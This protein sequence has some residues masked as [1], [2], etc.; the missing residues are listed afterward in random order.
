MMD[1]RRRAADPGRRKMT[2][3]GEEPIR[4]CWMRYVGLLLA[5]ISVTAQAVPIDT[6]K[7]KV[8]VEAAE[9]GQKT[10][11]ADTGLYY[12]RY[13][14]E[15]VEVLETDQHF[16]EKIQSAD[17]EDIKSGKISKELDLV[18]HHVRTKL[19]ELKR[20]EVARLRM[21]IKAKLSAPDSAAI[22]RKAL[23]QQFN[24][25][26]HMNPDSFEPQDLDMLI[27]AATKDLENFDK[28]RHDEFKR[29][30]MMKEHE[31]R[32]YLKTLNEVQ[33]K[34]EEAKYEEMKKKHK[35]HP[36]INHPGSQDQ[37]KEVWQETDG[38]DPSDFDPK[39]FF[40]LHDTN[41]DGFID[42]QE[43]EALFTKELEKAYDPKNEEDDMMEMEEER[44]RM[45]EHV[46][47]EVDVDKDRLINLQEFLRAT[48]KSDF[49]EPEGWEMLEEQQPY[50]EEELLEFERHIAQT[51]D[52]LNRKKDELDRQQEELQK[53][54]QHIQAQRQELQQVVQQMEQ[55][56]QQSLPPSV[57][58][59]GSQYQPG[60]DHVAHLG[61]VGNSQP[62]PPGH[63][64]EAAV[65][66]SQP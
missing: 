8:N 64:S 54:H 14:R 26:N 52:E 18:G 60:S 62:L 40:K 59:P 48:E 31:R 15:V 5:Y 29:Y 35:D 16:R 37:L 38:L 23:I 51:E 61:A 57:P 2:R 22:D 17:I 63:L 33:K 4:W 25:L 36:K 55:K 13:L 10:Q 32:E 43:L 56:K 42:E 7:T 1:A 6:D 9:E 27:R 34:E 58:E 65:P 53:Q 47:N 45:R 50:T 39:T 21:L 28:E 44:L 49:L 12:D 46:M 41:G 3:S 19:D 20:Q 66:H 30:E 24:H 11:S